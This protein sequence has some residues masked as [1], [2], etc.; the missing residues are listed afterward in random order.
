[1]ED[2]GSVFTLV[3]RLFHKDIHSVWAIRARGLWI[4][5]GRCGFVRTAS[6]AL[7]ARL[8]GVCH[9]VLL[10]LSLVRSAACGSPGG[11]EVV[12]S[13]RRPL[14]CLCSPARTGDACP[15]FG[16]IRQDCPQPLVSGGLVENMDRL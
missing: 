8:A 15:G 11:H 1:M 14:P 16:P 3:R 9:A 6:D 7:S 10:R 2:L 5:C 4:A 13:S 12:M